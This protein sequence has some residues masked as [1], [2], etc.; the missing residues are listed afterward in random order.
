MP[1]LFAF[2][3][4]VLHLVVRL[5][6]LLLQLLPALGTRPPSDKGRERP[7]EQRLWDEAAADPNAV[8]GWEYEMVCA[9]LDAARNKIGD[10]V[11]ACMNGVAP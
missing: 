10:S 8:R 2:G 5:D 7:A 4:S 3:L 6:A 11:G 1:E 9:D